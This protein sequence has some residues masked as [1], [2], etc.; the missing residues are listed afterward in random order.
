MS[1]N[2]AKTIILAGGALVLLLIA[3]ILHLN[4]NYQA[5]E[6][7]PKAVWTQTGPRIVHD[8]KIKAGDLITSPELGTIYYLNS[9]LERL[10]FPDEQTFLSWYPDYDDVITISRE[11]LESYPLSGRNVTI[12]PGTYLI[13]IPSS[14]QVWMISHPSNLHWLSGGEEQVIELFSESW[15]DIVVD[16][17]EYYFVNYNQSR[18]YASGDVYPAGLL[19]HVKSNDQYYLVTQS[20]QR[21]VTEE[22]LEANHLQKRFAIQRD[23]PIDFA[24]FGPVLDSYEARWASPDRKEQLADPGPTDIIIGEQEPEVG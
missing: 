6:P 19:V 3:G 15:K 2:Q 12:R 17:P 11:K 1:N 5:P 10:V 22:G 21:L 9:D 18:D 8:D 13:T 16:L 4:T 7:P 14:P 23:E 24:E 20:G